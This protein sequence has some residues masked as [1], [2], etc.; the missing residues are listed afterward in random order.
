MSG[1]QGSGDGRRRSRS[2]ARS[3]NSGGNQQQQGSK[4]AVAGGNS[5]GSGSSSASGSS[6]ESKANTG[7]T[8]AGKGGQKGASDRRG[9]TANRGGG[10]RGGSG[11]KDT[12]RGD[13]GRAS[14]R[15]GGHRSGAGRGGGGRRDGGRDGNRTGRSHAPQHG[16]SPGGRSTGRP[17]APTTHTHR[18]SSPAAGRTHSGGLPSGGVGR[19]SPATPYSAEHPQ[20][21]ELPLSVETSAGGLV[22]SGLAEAVRSDGSVDLTRIYVAL[23]GRLDRRGRL[24]WSMPKGHVEPEESQH[25]TAEREVWE[26]TGVSGEVIAD[27]GTIDY[28]FVSDGTRIH[29]TVHHH[30]LRFVDG[31]LNDEDPEVT[32]VAWLPVDQLVEHL[33]YADERRLAR[34]A[35]ERLPEYARAEAEAG[36]ATPR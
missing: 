13:T 3:R 23:I 5:S 25:A 2:R 19:R 9:N 24:L 17:G 27:L 34:T 35:F 28:W 32:E 4:S 18:S 36:R 7:P 26:E 30:L 6:A 12:G 1:S 31:D 29:K 33:A 20:H 14:N 10:G 21:S 11:R 22:L 16:R 15:T 8:G